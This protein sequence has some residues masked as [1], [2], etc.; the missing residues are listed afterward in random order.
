MLAQIQKTF[1]GNCEIQSF[2]A[3]EA[4]ASQILTTA[5]SLPFLAEAQILRV[6]QAEK[7]KEDALNELEVYL[8][9]PFAKTCLMLESDKVD[10]KSRLTKLVQSFGT[11]IRPAAGE[12]IKREVQFL[13]AR[14][15]ESKKPSPPVRKKNC[16][17]C[18]GSRLFFWP[19][20]WI[21]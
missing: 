11:V 20:W 2:D 5:R 8:K 1:S 16:L 15:A 10:E 13:K 18:A 7:L 6:R 4:L 14:L 9:N 12:K 17:K 21:V 19:R 3:G